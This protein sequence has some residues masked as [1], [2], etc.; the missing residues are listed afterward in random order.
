MK[1]AVLIA[2]AAILAF[3]SPDAASAQGKSD[4]KQSKM[5]VRD[6][7]RPGRGRTSD[8]RVGEGGENER[9]TETRRSDSRVDDWDVSGDDDDWDDDNGRRNRS[10]KKNKEGKGPKFCRNGE[11]HPVHGRQWCEEK[12]FGLGNDVFDTWERRQSDGILLPSP[13]RR[14]NDTIG[15]GTLGDILGNVI[16]GRLNARANRLNLDGPLV[17]RMQSNSELHLFAGGAPLARFV[18]LNGDRRADVVYFRR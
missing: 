12:G 6:E 4:K 7:S 8:G 1:Y 18:D 11:G 5:I 15:R 2:F 14:N 13:R 9:R 10:D 17:G 3:G 16:L